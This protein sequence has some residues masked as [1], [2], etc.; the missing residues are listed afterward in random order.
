[1]KIDTFILGAYETNCYILRESETA[2]DCLIVDVGLEPSRLIDF[3]R[4]NKLNAVAIVLTHG[5]ID[6]IAGVAA[7]RAEF[8]NIKVY[9][10]KLDADMLTE[11]HSNLSVMMGAAFSTEPADIF[12]EE[13]GVIG[14]AGIKLEVLHTP[15]HTPG[16]IC[17]YSK[18]EGIVFTDDSLFAD[19]I[20]RTDFPDGSMEKLITSIREKLVTLPDDTIIYPG[21]GPTTTIAQEKAHNQFLQ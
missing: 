15:G 3:S 8:P 20:G 6:H 21:H 9:I 17:L 11:A 5:H 18:D 19:S 13:K 14:E 10:H 7:L 1:M 16:G 4:Q 12:V 2:K